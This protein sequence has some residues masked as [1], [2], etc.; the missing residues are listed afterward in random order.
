MSAVEQALEKV[1][2]MDEVHAQRLLAWLSSEEYGR[3][4]SSSSGGALAMLGFARRFRAEGRSTQ[5][6]MKELRE[7]E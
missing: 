3:R 1:K 7:A 2:R 5:S 6:W 4:P